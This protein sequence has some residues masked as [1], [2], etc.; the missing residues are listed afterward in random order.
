M[1]NRLAQFCA[2]SA[3]AAALTGCGTVNTVTDLV[4]S[5]IPE[6]HS[7]RASIVVDLGEQEAYLYRGKHRTASSRISSGREGHRTPVGRFSV[8]RKDIDH[9]SSLYGN[10]V[11]N[12]GRVVKANVDSRKDSKPPHS[13]F[14]GAAMPFF[15]EFS[16]GYGLHQG[17]LP[18]VPASHGCIRMPY[19]KA[20]QFYEAAHVGTAVTV[21]P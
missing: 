15:V 6:R 13:H 16:P 20:R 5:H 11:D 21:R 9:R 17:Y 1:A 18:G 4:T 7:G 14:V 19:W 8:I 3:I 2:L 12:S 10:Y